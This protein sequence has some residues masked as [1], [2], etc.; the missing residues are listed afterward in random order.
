MVERGTKR[1]R[2]STTTRGK[3]TNGSA[4]AG[5][6]KDAPSIVEKNRATVTNKLE[7]LTLPILE[8]YGQ[9]AFEEL[10]S[11]LDTTLTEF[12]DEVSHLFTDMVSQAK[13]E[14]ERLR[15]L[16]ERE[17]GK[18]GDE[19]SRPVLPGEENMSEFERRIETEAITNKGD[20]SQEPEE[21]EEDES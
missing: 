21:S 4:K 11:R 9:P 12:S 16:L 19:N 8:K 10:M 17:D 3:G 20:D 1:T 2:K 6:D 7:E 18:E 13:D 5:A 15:G 14:H